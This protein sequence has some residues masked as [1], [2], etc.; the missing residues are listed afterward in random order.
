MYAKSFD[1]SFSGAFL[2]SLTS[3]LYANQ[4]NFKSNEK[5]FLICKEHFMTIPVV[6]FARKNFYL[7]DAISRKIS[8]FQAAGLMEH[9]HSQWVDKR[10]LKAQLSKHLEKLT[11][12]HLFGCFVLLI[13]GLLLSFSI[14][15]LEMIFKVLESFLRRW[16]IMKSSRSEENVYRSN[17]SSVEM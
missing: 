8:I 16:K 14:F 11:V 4:L 6:I 5:V 9:W 1:P 13:G 3:I 10:F 2:R 12:N 17:Q 7:V 15:L